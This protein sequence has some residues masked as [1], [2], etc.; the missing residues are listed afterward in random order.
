MN[1]KNV[2]AIIALLVIILF[3]ANRVGTQ[4][5]TY[6]NNG[7]NLAQV[8]T[9][10]QTPTG[11]VA[12]TGKACGGQVLISWNTVSGAT[13]YD[14]YGKPGGVRAAVSGRELLDKNL[15]P[16]GTYAYQIR[17][18]NSTTLSQWSLPPVTAVASPACAGTTP[19]P[20]VTISASPSTVTTGSPS[21]IT[22]SSTNA[23]SCTASGGWSGTQNTAGSISVTPSSSSTYTLDCSG[24]G[25][26][27]SQSTNVTVKT[28]PPPPPPTAPTLSLSASPT[29]VTSGSSS[30]LTWTSTNATSCTASGGWSGTKAVSDSEV[31]TP[32]NTSTYTLDCTG[33][34]GSVSKSTT[35]TVTVPPPSTKF[36]VGDS[37]QTTSSVNVRD[38]ANGNVL[39]TQNNLA[40]GTI[41]GGGTFAGGHHWWNVDFTN[42]PDGWSAESFLTG[43]VAPAPLPTVTISASP[44]TITS[45]S[46]STL[47]WSSTNATSCTASN[48]WTGTKGTSG[49]LSVTPTANTTYTLTCT[50]TGGTVSKNTQVYVATSGTPTAALPKSVPSIPSNLYSAGCT[51]NPTTASALQTAVNSAKGGDVICLSPGVTYGFTGA[52]NVPARSSSD[53]SGW[54]VIRTNPS[55]QLTQGQRIRPSTATNLAKIMIKEQRPGVIEQAIRINNNADRWLFLGLEVMVDPATNNGPANLIDVGPSPAAKTITDLPTDI[56]F[57]QVYAHGNSTQNITRAFALNGGAQTVKDSWC[58]EIHRKNTDSQCTISW[59]GSGPFLIENNHLESGSENIMWG[60]ADP[61]V[62]GLR[63]SDATVRGNYIYKPI[64]W[65][66]K[67]WLVKNLVE[68]KNVERILIENNV[69]DGAWTEG[70]QGQAWVFKSV[71][72]NNICSWCGS[73]DI[74]VRRNLIKNVGSGLHISGSPEPHPA[75]DLDRMVFEENWFEPINTTTTYNGQGLG[76]LLNAQARNIVVRNNVWEKLGGS[77]SFGIMLDTYSTTA[78]NQSVPAVTN[79]FVDN[80]ILPMGTIGLTRCGGPSGAGALTSPALAGSLSFAGNVYIGSQQTNYPAGTQFVADLNAALGTGKGIT[81]SQINSW[82]SGVVVA[83]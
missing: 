44:S 68:S 40:I 8:G 69:L 64:S 66:G 65:K 34:G 61:G 14:V 39:G 1:T 19:A 57:V 74:T 2:L 82:T 72:Q 59:A 81:K 79:L 43:Y 37:I 5:A 33:A 7:S 30:T 63:P 56:G 31:V 18:K 35:V 45:G 48:G 12:T 53:T 42:A 38:A 60:G 75:P 10:L 20:T 13:S 4:L 16:G 3:S 77:N 24:A 71:N 67:G 22:W 25:G 83:P 50:G 73:F 11:L 80:N 58:S 28:P 55:V 15:T 49:S 32:T 41:I 6:L 62:N 51:S 17:A 9:S 29:S 23:T 46:P 27:A 52:L 76:L 26:N 54:T 47:A 36:N 21:T 70:Q 78:C